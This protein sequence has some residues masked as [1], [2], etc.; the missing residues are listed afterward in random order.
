[1]RHFYSDRNADENRNADGH[2]DTDEYAPSVLQLW[3]R[4][5]LS[6]YRLGL[7]RLQSGVQRRLSRR[8]CL[9]PVY[10]HR[11][12][13]NADNHADEHR[14]RDRNADLHIDANLHFHKDANLDEHADI[15]QH[16][17]SD[18][19]ANANKDAY[20]EQHPDTDEHPYRDPGVL[21]LWRY[22][23]LS[24]YRRGLW[25]LHASRRLVL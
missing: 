10:P 6:G 18:Y 23:V 24:G 25:K 22:R 1:M 8:T 17:D 13:P 7:C 5:V 4:R 15:D 19:Y 14:D 16:T 3:C 20:N 12:T 11:Y 9:R 2:V 21:Q